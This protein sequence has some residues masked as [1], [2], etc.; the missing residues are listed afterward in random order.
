MVAPSSPPA[1]GEPEEAAPPG[2][3]AVEPD[4]DEALFMDD[5]L[6]EADAAAALFAAAGGRKE[7]LAPGTATGSG[8]RNSD[9]DSLPHRLCS[10][11]LCEVFSPPRVGKE[12]AKFGMTVGDAMDLTTG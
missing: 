5:D 11:D 8:A 4:E 7:E 6:G 9:P 1:M 10:M 3:N 2:P 12:A